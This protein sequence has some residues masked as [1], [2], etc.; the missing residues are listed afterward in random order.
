MNAGGNGAT[1]GSAGAGVG[2]A[3]GGKGGAAAGTGGS[4]NAGASTTGGNGGTDAAGGSAAGGSSAGTGGVGGC[5]SSAMCNGGVCFNGLCCVSTAAV[6]GDGCCNDADQACLFGQCVVPG[7]DCKTSIDCG[8]GS[9][10]EI[11]LGDGAGGTGGAGG[12]GTAGAGGAVCTQPIPAKG[13]CLPLPPVCDGSGG[14]LGCVPDCEYKPTAGKLNA[15]AKW[16]WGPTATTKPN[17]TDVW[18]TP[19]VGRLYDANCDG[20]VDELDPPNIV[21]VSGNV[22]AGAPNGSNCQSATGAGGLSG[23]HTGVLRLLDGHSGEEIWSLANAGG[24]SVGFAGTTVAL[25]DVDKDGLLDIVA[26]TGEGYVVLVDSTGKVLRKSDKPI[27]GN[28]SA[29]FGWGGGFSIADMD[30]DGFPEI[31]FASTVF[32]TTGGAITL[33]FTG[34]NGMGGGDIQQAL[35]TFVDLDGAADGH[36]ELLAGNT[37]YKVDGTTLWNVGIADGFPAVGDFNLD[38]KPEVV[39][40][41]GGKAWLLDGATGKTVMGPV[42]LPGTGSGGPPTVADFD[43]DGKPEFGVAMATFYSVLKPNYTTNTIDVLWKVPNHDLSSSVTGSSVFDFEGDGKAEVIYGDECFLW[44]FDGETGAVRFAAPHTSF[45]GTEASVVA[46]VDGDGHAEILM[47]S[48]GADPSSA[49]WG[50]LDSSGTPDTINGV[51]WTP[52][53]LPNKSYRGIAAFGDS[54][55]S[56]VGTRTLWNEHAYHV[57]NICDDQD[58]A[59]DA[60][61]V[62]GSIPKVEKQNWS[63]SWLNNF[64]Q[65]VQQKGL[66]NAPDPIVSLD[67]TCDTPIVLKVSIKNNGLATLPAGVEIDLYS[68]GPEA[69][70]GFVTTT[71]PLSPGQTQLLPFTTALSDPNTQFEAKIFVDPVNPNFHECNTANDDSAIV[72]PSCVK[73]LAT[74]AVVHEAGRARSVA[75]YP[76]P[77]R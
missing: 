9:Y 45:T 3:T 33:K 20:K 22:F 13:K 69:S 42:T 27:P 68:E 31:A 76:P 35:S 63:L 46:D 25:G 70:L 66:F 34:A 47:V 6:C 12:S 1:S 23:C 73:P 18:S 19:T 54:A 26:A 16:T 21:F 65:N 24:S 60:P 57:N 77:R 51:K 62:Y 58:D 52:S 5:T 64:R 38:G 43:G 4:A 56:W 29:T 48:N 55:N 74:H 30:G 10:C 72:K 14:P 61:N 7:K 37:A 50:C 11:A 49:G 32:T 75:L 59:C 28:G 17:S 67:A 53:T 39:N 71:T 15:S 40:V 44:V 36:L 41:T 8:M 2:G